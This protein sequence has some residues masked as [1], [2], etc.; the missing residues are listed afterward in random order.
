MPFLKSRLVVVFLIVSAI[1]VIYTVASYV[2]P[3]GSESNAASD[4]ALE[5]LPPEFGRLREVWAL[6]RRE[7]YEGQRLDGAAL[8]DGAIRG[9]LQA[10]D[11]PYASF[12]NSKQFALESE[13]LKGEF[14]G[15]GAEVG[16]RNG[17]VT[18]IAPLPD[19]PAERSGI[20]AGDIILEIDGENTA[21]MTLLE[22]VS[23]IRGP[24]GTPVMLSVLH[25]NSRSPVLI[26]VERGVI[27]LQS[28]RFLMLTGGIGHVRISVFSETTNQE[29]EEAL[30]RFKR[31]QGVG[32]VLDLRN[33]PGGLLSSVV[34]VASQFLNKGLVLY[35]IDSQGQRTDWKVRSGGKAL[36]IPMVVLVNEFSASASEV[37]SGAIIDHNRAPTVG[38]KTF[39]KGSVNTLRQLKDGSGVYFTIA[40]WF[41][42]GGTLIEGEGITPSIEV[43]NPEDQSEDL[44]I[45]KAIEILKERLP[46][47]G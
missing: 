22:T 3:S 28:V 7:H 12:L 21:S 35:E 23:R 26:S 1:A 2:L 30:A 24:K 40:R 32:L 43:V 4:Q 15:I 5:G 18:V 17:R 9:L 25:Q 31:A 10:L 38:S 11:D 6:L 44:Q 13:D 19:T 8:S 14:E 36:N 27:K 46:Q 42:P 29:L 33:N 16:M 37:F 41:T 34:E 47:R 45:E 39:G 20:K